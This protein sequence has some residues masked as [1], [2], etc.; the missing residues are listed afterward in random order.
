MYNDTSRGSVSLTVIIPFYLKQIWAIKIL[1]HLP[2]YLCCLLGSENCENY[3]HSD[4]F[5][6]CMPSKWLKTTNCKIPHIKFFRNFQKTVTKIMGETAI[7]II[8]CFYPLPPLNN[9]EKQW[10][11]LASS[12]VMG[13]QHCIEGEG[14]LLNTLFEIPIIFS[15]SL[16]KS[17]KKE[18]KKKM[19]FY[20]CSSKELIPAI[21]FK[22]TYHVTLNT[23]INIMTKNSTKMAHN[24]LE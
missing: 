6:N 1:T 11:K 21:C 17:Y 24:I 8:S 9:I 5:G 14:G 23:V 15:H 12:Y 3:Y 13:L 4:V 18:K 19:R 7:W 16:S 20:A 2:I 22:E 10:A